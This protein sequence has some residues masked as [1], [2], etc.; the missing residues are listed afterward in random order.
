MCIR[1]SPNAYENRFL[2]WWRVVRMPVFWTGFRYCWLNLID[3]QYVYW[4]ID[5]PD[6]NLYL[7]FSCKLLHFSLYTRTVITSVG[8]KSFNKQ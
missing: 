2:A 7:N 4:L 5:S 1:D 3:L 6:N 8:L